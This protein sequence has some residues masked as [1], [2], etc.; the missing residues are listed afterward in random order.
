MNASM[1]TLKSVGIATPMVEEGRERRLG[2]TTGGGGDG[3]D[4]HGWDEKKDMNGVVGDVGA[5][6]PVLERFGTAREM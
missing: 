5:N 6:R 2:F 3:V 4:E 1:V